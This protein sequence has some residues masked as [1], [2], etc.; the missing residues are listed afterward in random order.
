MNVVA[1]VLLVDI[2]HHGVEGFEPGLRA[3]L[4]VKVL[5]VD[6]VHH[7]ARRGFKVGHEVPF[8][9]MAPVVSLMGENAIK[10]GGRIRF[11]D[12]GSAVKS[13][14]EFI[15]DPAED[16]GRWTQI[17]VPCSL[18]SIQPRLRQVGPLVFDIKVVADLHILRKDRPRFP[19]PLA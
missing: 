2:V 18:L 4:V 16:R 10:S 3:P 14:I 12:A 19:V 11:A 6:I 8:M 15:L 13:V 17:Q 5:K 9:D 1:K 7:G